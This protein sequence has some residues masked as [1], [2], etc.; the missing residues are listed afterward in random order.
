M[1]F[2]KIILIFS[3][4]FFCFSIVNAEETTEPTCNYKAKIDECMNA[5]GKP[6]TISD[7]TCINGTKEEVT[8]Q[9]ILDDTFSQ[10]DTE[11]EQYL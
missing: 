11:V 6:R 10:I 9:I 4:L 1:K 5:Q 7:F 3:I 8:Y 2:L